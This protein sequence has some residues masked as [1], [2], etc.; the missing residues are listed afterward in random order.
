MSA[1]R[2]SYC[3]TSYFSSPLR[4]AR[5]SVATWMWCVVGDREIGRLRVGFGVVPKP[6]RRHRPR[7]PSRADVRRLAPSPAPPRPRWLY[8]SLHARTRSAD[9]N[10]QALVRRGG[11]PAHHRL[12]LVT[13]S[14]RE[15]YRRVALKIKAHDLSFRTCVL[16]I[17]RSGARG[18]CNALRS[19]FANLR[20]VIASSARSPLGSQYR[21]ARRLAGSAA[22]RLRRRGDCFSERGLEHLL[23][24]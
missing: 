17:G 14:Y 22:C 6:S 9:A 11:A 23:V 3:F 21:R 8:G 12:G 10:A 7:P 16:C 19:M 2:I 1:Q 20:R 5:L 15:I 4:V 18:A 13:A 24:T